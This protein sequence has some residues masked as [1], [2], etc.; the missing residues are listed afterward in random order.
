[1]HP[2]T[3]R[4]DGHRVRGAIVSEVVH[5]E[6]V[7]QRPTR[8]DMPPQALRTSKVEPAP[9]QAMRCQT[10]TRWSRQNPRAT[11]QSDRM[12]CPR[13][14]RVGKIRMPVTVVREPTSIGTL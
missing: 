5:Q 11:G 8:S 7:F 10:V 3:G 14:E 4:I 12:G 6:P 2:F 9:A 13:R 1:M